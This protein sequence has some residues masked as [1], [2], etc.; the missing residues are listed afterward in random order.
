MGIHVP[1]TGYN[2]CAVPTLSRR[3][4]LRGKDTVSEGAPLSRAFPCEPRSAKGHDT[5]TPK[6]T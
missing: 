3:H 5:N 4:E 1:K 6:H 2:P